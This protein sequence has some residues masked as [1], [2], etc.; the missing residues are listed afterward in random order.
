MLFSEFKKG[1]DYL[2]II[3]EEPSEISSLSDSSFEVEKGGLFFVVKGNNTDGELYV[4]EAIKRGCVAIVSEKETK[5][6]VCQIIVKDIKVAMALACKTFY[7]NAQ[8]DLRIIGVVGTNGKTTVCHVL[9]KIFTFAGYSVGVMGTLGVFY[10]GKAEE[11]NLTTMGCL[12]LYKTI[13]D[14]VSH[15]VTVLVME[16]SAHAIEQRRVEGLFFDALI[17]T[18]CT[19]DHLDY[20]K[21]MQ[22]YKSVKKSLFNSKNCRFMIVN[23]DDNTGVEIINENGEN[24]ISY[25]IE[26]PADVFAINV[27]TAKDGISFVVNVFDLIYD[28]KSKLIGHFNVYNLLACCACSALFNV[29]IHQIAYALKNIIPVEGRADLVCEYKGASVFI[30]YA[31]TPDG[32]KQTL[33]AMRKICKNKLICVFG[34]GGNREKEK[35]PIMGSVSGVLCDFTIVTTDNPRF[36]DENKIIEEIE[37]GITPFT[38]N[39]ATIPDRKYA[40]KMGLEMLNFGDILVV[41]GKGAE[42]YQEVKGV[43]TPFSDREIILQIVNENGG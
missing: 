36:E 39:Y 35:R 27:E 9:S 5:A 30:D 22:T 4:S 10:G 2:K 43:K 25:G 17:F 28:L 8:D 15:G 19:E 16:V 32:L 41:A 6:S 13:N 40:V 24:V 3:G 20:F 11:S 34:C 14:M 31:H 21:D 12:N 1:V 23:S 38:K 29:K 33:L 26:N 37:S 7:G 18:N 42:K